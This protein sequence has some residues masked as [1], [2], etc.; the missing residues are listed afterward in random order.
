MYMYEKEN[1]SAEERRAYK[2]SQNGTKLSALE[3]GDDTE[4]T[5]QRIRHEHILFVS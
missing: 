4:I 2:T 1:G 3:L 5:A